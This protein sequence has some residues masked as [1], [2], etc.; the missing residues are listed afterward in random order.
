MPV[1]AQHVDTIALIIDMLNKGNNARDISRE[2]GID[3]QFEQVNYDLQIFEVRIPSG[4]DFI[5]VV[6]ENYSDGT[7]FTRIYR[8]KNDSDYFTNR[9]DNLIFERRDTP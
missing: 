1:I 5:R 3:E 6:E 2:F 9:W 8:A 4:Y 7:G